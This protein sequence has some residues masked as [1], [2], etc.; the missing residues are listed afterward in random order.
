MRSKIL[1]V[2]VAA[3][4]SSSP[5]FAGSDVTFEISQN[6]AT[7]ESS[8]AT[9][10]PD[11]GV[12]STSK[13]SS[14]RLGSPSYM[15][16]KASCGTMSLS[17][18]P[19][20]VFFGDTT[21]PLW[22]GYF[23]KPNL[24]LVLELGLGSK[25]DSDGDVKSTSAKQRIGFGAIYTLAA[26][27]SGGIELGGDISLQSDKSETKSGD[28][29]TEG[30]TA[31]S[32]SLHVSAGYLYTASPN[33]SYYAGVDYSTESGKESQYNT[34]TTSDDE[35]DKKEKSFSMTLAQV[36]YTFN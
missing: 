15:M 11:G 6:L 21:L 33:L 31:K 30:S 1:L 14:L 27:G 18:V 9:S 34:T 2:T 16:L 29:K 28:T 17:T 12:S 19:L 3:V 22:I 24:E 8:T 20:M 10:E 32:T 7:Y 5:A 23:P 13:D 35:T 26:G 36:R 4:L 25:K